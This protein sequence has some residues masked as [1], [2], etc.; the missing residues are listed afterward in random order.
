MG[1]NTSLDD[2]ILG[3]YQD[4]E[5]SFSLHISS[6]TSTSSTNSSS[7]LQ[8]PSSSPKIKKFKN[9]AQCVFKISPDLLSKIQEETSSNLKSNKSSKEEDMNINSG[10]K[11]NSKSKSNS[12]SNSSSS[13]DDLPTTN[14]QFFRPKSR[15]ETKQQ[16]QTRSQIK[17]KKIFEETNFNDTTNNNTTSPVEYHEF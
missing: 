16:Q 10:L 1:C 17:V 5:D 9:M 8:S 2:N 14:S 12:N 11:S 6:P 3:D 13:V 15:S 7:S 4:I